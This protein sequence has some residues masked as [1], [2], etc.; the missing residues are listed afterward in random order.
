MLLEMEVN[1]ITKTG[2]TLGKFIDGATELFEGYIPI[3]PP[4]SGESTGRKFT[5]Y[6]QHI[7]VAGAALATIAL[8]AGIA[9]SNAGLIMGAALVTLTSLTASSYIRKTYYLLSLEQD[10]IALQA[11]NKGLKDSIASM[12]KDLKDF[13]ASNTQLHNEN[14]ALDKVNKKAAKVNA[15]LTKNLNKYIEENVELSHNVE[16]LEKIPGAMANNLGELGQDIAKIQQSSQVIDQSLQK[17]LE[18]AEKTV[19]HQIELLKQSTAGHIQTEQYLQQC[20]SILDNVTALYKQ[21]HEALKATM[22]AENKIDQA[23]TKWKANDII[24]S[25]EELAKILSKLDGTLQGAVAE[26]NKSRSIN[27]Q[28][29]SQFQRSVPF[30]TQIALANIINN[31]SEQF[32]YQ[33]V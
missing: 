18:V 21:S 7:M 14:T 9:I 24:A 11:V 5:I 10:V 8:V 12:D 28:P 17:R 3:P 32:K 6:T 31:T 25:Q 27:M 2:S 13:K 4:S 20:K 22:E 29:P 15:D 26:L 23:Y 33:K 16:E 1:M 30:P 19:L